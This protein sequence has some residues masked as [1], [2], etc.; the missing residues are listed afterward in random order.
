MWA[1]MSTIEK[2]SF[3]LGL[4]F[5]QLQQGLTKSSQR[6]WVPPL[7]AM[8]PLELATVES[9][10]AKSPR[11]CMVLMRQQGSSGWKTRHWEWRSL[12][13]LR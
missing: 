10:C 4:A 11:V 7:W 3:S 2:S 8:E 1:K 12:M 13:T 9:I 6:I 5:T